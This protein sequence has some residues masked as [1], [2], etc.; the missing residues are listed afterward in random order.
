MEDCDFDVWSLLEN[1]KGVV[2]F[3]TTNVTYKIGF[4]IGL[5]VS[6]ASVD[7][8]TPPPSHSIRQ[9]R[10]CPTKEVFAISLGRLTELLIFS[11]IATERLRTA[12]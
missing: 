1:L 12:F 6:Q 3:A 7:S 10:N 8:E 11:L 5:T 4:A 2:A 9:V